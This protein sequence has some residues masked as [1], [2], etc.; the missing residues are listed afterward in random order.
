MWAGPIFE[1]FHEKMIFP[2]FIKDHF[3]DVLRCQEYKKHA[4]RLNQ[5]SGN[6]ENHDKNEKLKIDQENE[7]ISM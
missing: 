2:N 3:Y 6:Q 7:Q 5:A 1:N 4:F